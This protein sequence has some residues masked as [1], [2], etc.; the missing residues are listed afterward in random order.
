MVEIGIGGG[1]AVAV[2]ACASVAGDGDDGA[3]GFD[4]FA[5]AVVVFIGD[6]EVAFGIEGH[7]ER[8][9]EAGIGSGHA[10]A[11]IAGASVASHGDDGAGGLQHLADAVVVTVGD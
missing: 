1:H 7:S 5:D 4:N 3:R 2:I 9:I 6:E 10:I 11:V 8:I